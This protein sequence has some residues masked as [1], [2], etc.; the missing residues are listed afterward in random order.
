MTT[1][2]ELYLD[3]AIETLKMDEDAK[4]MYFS[5]QEIADIANRTILSVLDKRTYEIHLLNDWCEQITNGIMRE[6]VTLEKPFKIWVNCILM[7]KADAH[8]YACQSSLWNEA[9]DGQV[10]CR[11]CNKYM[12]CFV[13]VLGVHV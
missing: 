4:K 5:V 13:Q 2:Q 6:I 3:E 11:W 10:I 8:V 9:S 12:Q 1:A 7:E